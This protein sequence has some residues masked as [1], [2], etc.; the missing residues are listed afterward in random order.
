MKLTLTSL[1]SDSQA[2]PS[3]FYRHVLPP[4]RSKFCR[5]LTLLVL[6]LAGVLAMKGLLLMFMFYDWDPPSVVPCVS[7]NKFS[8]QE[9]DCY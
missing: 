9:A 4:L 5:S 7:Y 3:I 6:L 1:Q 8:T 2:E